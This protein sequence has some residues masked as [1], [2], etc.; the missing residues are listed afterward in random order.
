MRALERARSRL[1]ALPLLAVLALLLGLAG[2]SLVLRT[3]ALLAGFWIDEGLAVGIASFP[4]DEIPGILRQDGSP[5]LY[6]LLLHAW[7]EVFGSGEGETHGLSVAFAVLTVPAAWWAARRPWGERAAWIAALLA[8]AHPFLTFYAQE[9]RMYALVALLG[10]LLAGTFVRAFVLRDRRFLA[11]FAVCAALLLYTHNWG[12]FLMVGSLGALALC[13]RAAAERRALLRDAALAYG[14]V[15]LAYAAWLPTLLFQAQNTG[16]PWAQRPGLKELLN[17][18][19]AAFGG[20]TSAM[21]LVLAAG[22]GLVA[23]WTARREGE[24]RPA[25]QVRLAVLAAAALLFGT[26]IVGWLA[27]QASPAWTNRYLAVVIGPALLLAAVGLARARGLGIAA[28]ILL[29]SLWITAREGPL[30]G[31]SNVR[32]V[33]AALEQRAIGP[34]DLVVSTHPEQVPVLHY[35]L[36]D[37]IRFASSLGRVSEPRIMDWRDAL[38]RLRAT[39]PTPTADALIEE[40]APGQRL[41]LVQPIIRRVSWRAPWTRLVRRRAAQWELVL[42][43]DPRLRR[44]VNVP[45]KLRGIPRGVRAVIYRV[46]RARR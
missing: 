13:A 42:D 27:S 28:L 21:V 19:L 26:L 12:L 22:S 33:A 16:A 30:N 35:Y 46:R 14:G 17:G 36:G 40:V 10:L 1:A 34:R 29:A 44:T 38:D 37:E 45:R 3:R 2:L 20:R 23:L 9:T 8:A 32:V 5:P 18:T 15:G 39:R 4:L 31:K 25:D 11:P 41:V 43:R 24:G 6:Y 7:M